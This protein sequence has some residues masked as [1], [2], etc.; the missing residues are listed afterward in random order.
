MPAAGYSG[1][2]DSFIAEWGAYGA[3]PGE[4]RSPTSI[5]V[6]SHN[7]VYVADRHNHRIQ[8]FSSEGVF[9][10]EWGGEGLGDGQFSD[11]SAIAV[12]NQDIVFVLEGS[13]VQMFTRDGLFL[14][15]WNV[16][17]RAIDIDSEGN[18]YVG[19]DWTVR[20]Y[21]SDGSLLLQWGEQ[22]CCQPGQFNF[23]QGI[24]V[25][26]DDKVFINDRYGV[27]FQKFDGSGSFLAKWTGGDVTLYD[28]PLGID[29][30]HDGFVYI[31]NYRASRI[32]VFGAD[33]SFV[34]AWGTPGS[35]AGE[36]NLPWDIACDSEGRVYVVEDN[37]VQKFGTAP[38]ASR[39]ST[40]GAI[41][42][43]FGGFDR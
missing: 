17:G 30:D 19:S 10:T 31:V 32:R 9:L 39:S 11:P 2:A 23:I 14:G 13:R 6:D 42:T 22:G 26:D 5:A 38:T 29:V 3:G 37:R 7:D 43:M 36:L 15:R 40:W 4:F 1:V 25:D 33:G 35:G 24:T 41:K 12:N 8:K 21:A 16:G 18:V 27:Y 34:S 20:K 28:E